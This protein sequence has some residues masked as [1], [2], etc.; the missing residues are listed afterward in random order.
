MPIL[1]TVTD[2]VSRMQ[3]QD[4]YDRFHSFT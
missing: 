2:T 4:V 1:E 3:R